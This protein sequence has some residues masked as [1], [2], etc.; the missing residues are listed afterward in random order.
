MAGVKAASLFS[1]IGAPEVA[2]PHWH[3]LW[4][5]EIERFPSAVMAARHPGSVNLGDVCAPDFVERALAIG[6]P[7]VVVFGSPCQ[8]FSV[9]GKRLGL[10]DPRGN[11]ALFA[12][13][14][15]RRIRPRWLLF[16]NVPGLLSSGGGRD[17]GAFLGAVAECGYLGVWRVLDAQFAGVPQR[18][19]R[20]F[21][22]GHLGDWR[23]AAAVLLEPGSLRGN[24]APGKQ[25]RQEVAGSLGA[26]S[27]RSGGRVG[28][29]EAAAGQL[30][31]RCVTA[32]EG[33]RQDYESET[34]IAHSLRADGFDASEDGTGRG[35][36][37]VPVAF[38]ENQRAEITL[39]DTAGS[40]NVGGGKP[41]Q[42]YP[43][44]LQS[45]VRRLTVLE[46]ER[47]MGLPD[48][49]TRIPVKRLAKKPRT[50]HFAKYPDLYDRQDDGSWLRHAADGPRYRACGNRMA[51]PVVRWILQRLE[52]EHDR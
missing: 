49:W 24:S 43:A 18:R 9:A 3:W 20:V 30:L 32:R 50:K 25:S 47:L 41:G 39:S 31:S 14:L 15:L 44:I 35:T 27:A 12:L 38:H 13:A 33:S 52:R 11:L 8:S 19:R 51:V 16:E 22:V 23:P 6:R 48:G 45:A 36:P 34:L 37:L 10:D 7:D 2:M 46:C 29:R 42:G 40:L 26:D 17:F 28:R 21:F 5:A 4:H 1:G